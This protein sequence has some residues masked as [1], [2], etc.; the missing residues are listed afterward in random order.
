MYVETG[1]DP[2]RFFIDGL[3]FGIEV[4]KVQEV[5]RAQEMTRAPLAPKV[6][7]PTASR[8]KRL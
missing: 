1:L 5:L 6:N 2:N 3:C 8:H 4:S 7:S